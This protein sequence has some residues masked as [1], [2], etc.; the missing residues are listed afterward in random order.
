MQQTISTARYHKL[1]TERIT[2]GRLYVDNVSH[3]AP[4]EDATRIFDRINLLEKELD[5][6]RRFR[7]DEYRV[8]LRA[9][10]ERWHVPGQPPLGDPECG[11]CVK[12]QLHV[13]RTLVLRPHPQASANRDLGEAS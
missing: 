5:A 8:V 6:F 1:L 10:D 4:F 9:E 13:S 12:V 11:L 2:M 7:C 3:G